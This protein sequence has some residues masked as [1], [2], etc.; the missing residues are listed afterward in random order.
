MSWPWESDIFFKSK[1][2]SLYIFE[3]FWTKTVSSS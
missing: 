2:K 1:K 3:G